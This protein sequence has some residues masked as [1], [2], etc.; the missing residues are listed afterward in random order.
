VDNINVAMVVENHRTQSV[1]S[2]GRYH[3]LFVAC[4]LTELGHDVILLTQNKPPFFDEFAKHYQMPKL[5][6]T[7]D[8]LR[9]VGQLN[10]I[11]LV[12]GYPIIWSAVALKVARLLA[13]PCFNF[14]LD[15]FPLTNKYAPAV[16]S[17]M[18]Y[19]PRHTKALQDSDLLLSI[20]DFAV[21]YIIEWTGNQNTIS[22]MGCVNSRLADTVSGGQS[23]RFVAITRCT[24]HKRLSDLVYVANKT[25][26]N[27]DIITSHSPGQ[28]AQRVN[29]VS[30]RIWVHASL[31]DAD[32]LEMIK[33]AR[34]LICPSAY[35]G[36]GIPAMEAMYCGI[37]VICYDFP[38]LREVCG[39]GALYASYCSPESLANQV[40][41]IMKDD[42]LRQDLA[43]RAFG[44]GRNYSF[45]ALCKRLREVI[46]EWMRC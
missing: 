12:I 21:P 27:I 46:A 28:V 8:P 7:P 18:H 40:K 30:D 26:A 33:S 16:A 1:V 39:N 42:N 45:E 37:P 43:A 24:E 31:S 22:L 44:V 11:D 3:A 32:K 36:L 34:A 17:R 2:G 4:A 38:I 41:K 23:D 19:G 20:S 25:K 5:K 15:A 13:V 35:E 29:S 14:V 6:L 9:V 10:H